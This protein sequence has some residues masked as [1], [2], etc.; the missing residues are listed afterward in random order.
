MAF[1]RLC[2]ATAGALQKAYRTTRTRRCVY[3]VVGRDCG[4]TQKRAATPLAPSPD[5]SERR[6]TRALAVVGAAYD[7]VKNLPWCS[8]M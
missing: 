6:L 4:A 3:G 8:V 2:S 7:T 1:S 5:A